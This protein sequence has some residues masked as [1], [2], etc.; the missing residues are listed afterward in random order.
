MYMLKHFVDTDIL[1][2]INLQIEFDFFKENVAV[3]NLVFICIII[4]S[5]FIVT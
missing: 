5:V 2:K 4:L 3:K 1:T